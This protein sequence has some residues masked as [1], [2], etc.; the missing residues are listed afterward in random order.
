M[1][2]ERGLYAVADGV[3]SSSQGSGG[4]AAELALAL[5]KE[6]FAG[7]LVV[8]VDEVHKKIVELRKSDKTIG[9]TTLTAA[10]VGEDAAE[11]VN[12]GDSPS[13]LLRDGELHLL[14]NPDK[15]ELG[16]I[17]QVIGYPESISVHRVVV[18]LRG[19]DF[20]I[21]ASDG[22]E[23]VL[24]LEVLLPIVAAAASSDEVA[25]GHRRERKGN[26]GGIR[27]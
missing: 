23:H 18:E 27:R 13:Y 8:T 14:T 9:E 4:V 15:S 21:L 20:L 25:G 2:E 7:D 22:V 10:H 5:L 3:T 6:L 1:D 24:N 12:V 17:T 11:V 19:N 16:Y 26:F